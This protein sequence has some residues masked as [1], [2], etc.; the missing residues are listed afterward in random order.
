MSKDKIK[1]LRFIL[2][3]EIFAIFITGINYLLFEIKLM[4]VAFCLVLISLVINI[5]AYFVEKKNKK[6]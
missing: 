2:V 6:L 5:Y 1:I 4:G 3:V